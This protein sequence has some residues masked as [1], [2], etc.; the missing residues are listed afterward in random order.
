[1]QYRRFGNSDL[2]VSEI[3]FG[4][5]R[6]VRGYKTQ[7][8]EQT[9]KRALRAAIDGGVNTIHSSTEYRTRWALTDVLRD[10]PKR[11]ELHHIIK[12]ET[13][14][15]LDSAFDPATF[16]K[17]VEDALRELHAERI[18]VVQH[19]Q[20]GPNVEEASVHDGSGDPRRIAALATIGPE[21]EDTF[22]ELKREGK[23]GWLAT[24]PH[25]PGYAKAAI[26]SGHFHGVVAYFNLLETEMYPL[27]DAMRERGMG[28]FGMKPFLEGLITDERASEVALPEGDPRRNPEWEPY[29][30]RFAR[31]QEELG[32]EVGSW[33]ELAVKF[34]LADPLMPSV[35]LSMDTPGQVEGALAAADGNYPDAAFVR[36]VAFLNGHLGGAMADGSDCSGR[37]SAQGLPHR[38]PVTA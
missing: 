16:R 37:V 4:T 17:K 14:D 28:Y 5:L 15:Y 20:R 12:V 31:L 1:V 2:E 33:T 26:E 22:E 18:A 10:H 35:I 9:G 8:D 34:A 23:I 36:R 25:T 19:L 6:F 30:G 7:N 11:H 38:P 32:A 29:Y 27:L 21:V 13:P 3:A 24:F